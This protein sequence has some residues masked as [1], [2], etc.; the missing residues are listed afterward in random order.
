MGLHGMAH[1]ARIH[2]DIIARFGRFP[3]RNAVLGRKSTLAEIDFL[4]SGG[5]AG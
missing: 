3:H 2:L 5:F 1:W 4:K